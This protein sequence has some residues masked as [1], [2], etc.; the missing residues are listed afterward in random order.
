MKLFRVRFTPSGREVE[1]PPGTTLL[2]AAVKAGVPI[3][4]SCG[5]EGVCA[6]CGLRVVAGG[7]MLAPAS[8]S[9]T[10]IKARNRLDPDLRLACRVV[11]CCDL[12]VTASYW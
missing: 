10:R 5:A 1:V 8:E 11:V 4:R 2:E 7:E 9:E 12:T 3:A 6:K